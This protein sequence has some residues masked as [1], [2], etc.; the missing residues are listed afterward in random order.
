MTGER[1]RHDAKPVARGP[2]KGLRQRNRAIVLEAIRQRGPVSRNDL[3]RGEALSMPT[4][5]EIT[6]TLISEGLVKEDGVGPSTGGRRPV[7]LSLVDD[8]LCAIG[9]SIGTLALT[10]VVTDLAGRVRLRFE[11]PSGMSRGPEALSKSV[12]EVVSEAIRSRPKGLGGPLGIGLALPVPVA[13]FTRTTLSPPTYPSWGRANI[14]EMLHQEYGLPVLADNVANAAALGEHQHGAG[15]GARDMFYVV[16]HRGIGGA[17]VLNGEIYRGVD[18][19][20]G[21]IGH[22]TI[23][24]DGP[25][26]GCGNK[27][28]LEAFAGRVGIRRRAQA[29]LQAAGRS[30]LAGKDVEGLR[31]QD[32]VEAALSGDGLA[33]DVLVETGGYLGVG[34]ANIIHLLNPELV[35]VGGSTMR[36]GDLVL[37]P[38]VEAVR[39]QVLPSVARIPP[40]VLG[41]L[42]EQAGAVGA[43]ALVL[44]E[45]FAYP[46][47][48]E[49]RPV[50]SRYQPR[51]HAEIGTAG[52]EGRQ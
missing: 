35:V 39:H 23:D 42:G 13:A 29:A 33:R 36:A 49:Q 43:A 47:P 6:G 7:L 31:A 27:G 51:N 34:I 4:V 25:R 2:L 50:P 8:A 21:E 18:R 26:C 41:E 16:A 40:V 22:M 3:S 45:L 1:F 12:L 52:V 24:L 14:G 44:R 37:E 46:A 11:P 48:G 9:L 15:R 28:C 30:S 5:L 17:A 19:G 38:A 32:V 20:A 10:A